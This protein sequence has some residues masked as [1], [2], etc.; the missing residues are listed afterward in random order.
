[1]VIGRGM[2]MHV[3]AV[4]GDC[5]ACDVPVP[6]KNTV[7]YSLAVRP[8]YG[9]TGLQSFCVSALI[10]TKNTLHVQVMAELA[11]PPAH[12]SPARIASL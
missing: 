2:N 1:M 7:S 12:G 3:C 8:Y 6:E 4:D 9:R 10:T 5:A 11:L